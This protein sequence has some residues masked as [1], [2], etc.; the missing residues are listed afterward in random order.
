MPHIPPIRLLRR[1]K[2]V[3]ID[4]HRHHRRPVILHHDLRKLRFTRG[5]QI[6]H[7]LLEPVHGQLC[8]PPMVLRR[9]HLQHIQQPLR[10]RLLLERVRDHHRDRHDR[11]VRLTP[12][13]HR[14][15]VPR[16][17]VQLLNRHMPRP[18]HLLT[19]PKNTHRRRPPLLHQ[20]REDF[21]FIL[22]LLHGRLHQPLHEYRQISPHGRMKPR[23]SWPYLTLHPPKR[24]HQHRHI[25]IHDAVNHQ[26]PRIRGPFPG[27]RLLV[28]LRHPLAPVT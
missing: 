24:F 3:L 22:P 19:P 25:L 1:Q 20:V 21:K 9:H 14:L 13:R 11:R 15:K 8:R 28:L 17:G 2:K 23:S 5:P 18:P 10:R 4:H 7:H 26:H 27:K 6:P 12:L 16:H